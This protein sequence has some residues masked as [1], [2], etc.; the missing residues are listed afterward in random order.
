MKTFDY[1]YDFTLKDGESNLK[2]KI[3][4]NKAIHEYIYINEPDFDDI[5]IDDLFHVVKIHEMSRAKTFYY[6]FEN[7]LNEK[8]CWQFICEK[9]REK[10]YQ[11]GD[12]D[13]E[14]VKNNNCFSIEEFNHKERS[15]VS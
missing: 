1:F 10:S 11:D 6:L 7:Y 13:I 8:D 15:K 3:E 14:V 5:E 9:H 2:V 12:L 4:F